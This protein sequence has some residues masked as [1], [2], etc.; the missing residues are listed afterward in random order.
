VLVSC[1]TQ[2]AA[3]AIA[4]V[5]VRLLSKQ[6]NCLVF[7]GAFGQFMLHGCGYPARLAGLIGLEVGWNCHAKI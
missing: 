2:Q 6:L 3:L 5:C 7:S 4:T 1:L